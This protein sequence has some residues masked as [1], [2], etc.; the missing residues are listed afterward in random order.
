M[1][2]LRKPRNLVCWQ[3]TCHWK[4]AVSKPMAYGSV[5]VDVTSSHK[6]LPKSERQKARDAIA[7]EV[8]RL[9]LT[10]ARWHQS[11]RYDSFHCQLIWHF[12]ADVAWDDAYE[13]T[14]VSSPG[15]QPQS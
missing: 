9:G 6:R 13:K 10:Y 4:N 5:W 2:R 14:Q 3:C 11:C 7:D 1:Q 12:A 8:K 15:E